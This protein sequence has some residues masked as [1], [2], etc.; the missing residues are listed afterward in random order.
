MNELIDVLDEKGQK[1]GKTKLR[2]VI[3]H[4]GD[5]HA[6]IHLWVVKKDEVL[7]QKRSMSKE[8]FPGCYDA[9]VAGHVSAGEDYRTAVIR[10]CSEEIG[11]QLTDMQIN[12]IGVLPL[13]IGRKDI[14]FISREHN[15]VFIV[16]IERDLEIC[17]DEEEIQEL[18]WMRISDIQQ[19]I[20]SGNPQY[21]ISI[22]EINLLSANS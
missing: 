18:K 9:T 19:E 17:I 20:E 8:S 1:T 21:C 6:S 11:V 3:H 12:E 13:V 15:H 22:D 10:E 5:W 4:D 16:E 14:N 2:D 7:L